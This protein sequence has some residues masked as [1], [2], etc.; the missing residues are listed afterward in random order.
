MT[1]QTEATEAAPDYSS[2]PATAFPEGADPSTYKDSLTSPQTP[3]KAE[4]PDHIPEKFWDAEAGAIRAED[5]A[6]SYA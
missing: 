6:K 2:L 5:M 1:I 4:R 3:A